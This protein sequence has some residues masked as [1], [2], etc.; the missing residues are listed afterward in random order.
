LFEKMGEEIA[1]TALNSHSRRKILS[2]EARLEILKESLEKE[3]FNVEWERKGDEY[4]IKELSC[5]YYQIGQN[6]PEVC[7]VDQTMIS[8]VL[9]VPAK[10]IKCILNGDNH[11]TY[12]INTRISPS[13]IANSEG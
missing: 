5:P 3:G 8:N 10:K 6:H 12:V 2:I 7:A 9:D 4:Y 13:D 1:Y 11:C